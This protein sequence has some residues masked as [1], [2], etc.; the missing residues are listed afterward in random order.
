MDWTATTTTITRAAELPSTPWRNGQGQTT[1][2]AL[3][4]RP[5]DFAWRVSLAEVA[6]DSDFSPFPGVDRII[7][8]V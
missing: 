6:R 7:M 4:G 5:D 8:L 2:I 1:E 3:A